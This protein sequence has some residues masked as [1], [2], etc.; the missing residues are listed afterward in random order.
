[1]N[2]PNDGGKTGNGDGRIDV[3]LMDQLYKGLR[4]IADL[5]KQISPERKM[6]EAEEKRI[7]AEVELRERLA[8]SSRDQI[9]PAPKNLERLQRV[10]EA[11]SAIKFETLASKA[12]PVTSRQGSATTQRQTS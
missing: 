11:R 1:M 12:D 8:M 7:T 6:T 9:V 2:P 3:K 10:V 4:E 5:L